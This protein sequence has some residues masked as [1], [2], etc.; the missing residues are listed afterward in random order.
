MFRLKA[1]SVLLERERENL[2]IWKRTF[3]AKET[4]LCHNSLNSEGSKFIIHKVLLLLYAGLADP[5]AL[6]QAVSAFQAC[7]F[8][9]MP[10]CEVPN[11]F[12]FLFIEELLL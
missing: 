8:I 5:N 10:G 2:K 9:G 4:G 6:S 3:T 7:Q 12:F 1:A 11:S